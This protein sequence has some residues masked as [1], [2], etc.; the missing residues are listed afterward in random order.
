[1]Q[2]KGDG[3]IRDEVVGSKPLRLERVPLIDKLSTSDIDSLREGLKVSADPKCIEALQDTIIKVR[4]LYY[5]K[6][7]RLEKI[8]L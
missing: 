5:I 3:R 6:V 2:I 4:L 1:V 8:S 7:G